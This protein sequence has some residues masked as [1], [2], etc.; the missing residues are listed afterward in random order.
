LED[1]EAAVEHPNGLEV[2]DALLAEFATELQKVNVTPN[3]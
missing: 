1:A 2:W 3:P